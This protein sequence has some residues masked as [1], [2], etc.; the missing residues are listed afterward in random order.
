MCTF[1]D[2]FN[3]LILNLRKKTFDYV[4]S[5][6]LPLLSS[7]IVLLFWVANLQVIGLLAITLISCF[8]LIVF[9]DLLPFVSLLFMVPM[10]FRDTEIAFQTQLIPC[11]IIFALLA[12]AIIF[13]FIKY[14][15][16]KIELDSFFFTLLSI[17]GI[18]LV[19]GLFSGD[20]SHY[21][22]AIDIFLI[23]GISPLLIHVVLY[24]NIKV[25]NKIDLKKYLCMGFLIAISLACFELCFVKLHVTLY[26]E[27]VF[28]DIPGYLCWANTNNF[29][30]LILIAIPLCCY[31]LLSSKHFW[32]WIGDLAF[33]CLALLVSG[34]DGAFAT[35]GAFT[36]FL[37]Y[38]VYKNVYKHNLPKLKL[39]YSCIFFIGVIALAYVCL[40]NSAILLDFIESSSDDRG[41]S[42]PYTMAIKLF[43][44]FPLF[45]IG[46]GGGNAALKAVIHIFD[47]NGFFHS[48]FFHILA[49]TGAVGIIGYVFYYL[50][51]MKYLLNNDTVLGNF[52]LYSFI[53]FALYSLIDTNEFNIVLAFMTTLITIVGLINKK[54]S[55]D[56]PLPLWVKN[57]IFCHV[58]Q[59]CK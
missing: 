28:E 4:Y 1:M 32:V 35:L 46:L 10:A 22:D 17:V 19:G 49:C 50:A 7:L 43:R 2:K 29:A 26:G 39:V 25:D 5:W 33:L 14:P 56:K 48:T 45:G 38:M 13:H 9:D 21:F 58:C 55:D 47:Y 3:N 57:P 12:S 31:M 44:S 41:R 6:F 52:V 23:A 15:A 16:K 53:L 27:V 24:N 37:M 42:L 8:V 40:F 54:G 59:S 36:P 30:T 51:R 18:F 11:I 34:S 20:Y